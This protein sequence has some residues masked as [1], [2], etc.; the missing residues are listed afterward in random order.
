[1][2]S[3]VVSSNSDTQIPR[4]TH[5]TEVIEGPTY[6]RRKLQFPYGVQENISNDLDGDI[7]QDVADIN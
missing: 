6:G 1:M 5:V 2:T 3:S 4:I 7:Y